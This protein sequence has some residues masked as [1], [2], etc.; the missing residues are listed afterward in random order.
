M[1][2]T[3]R[4]FTAVRLNDECEDEDSNKHKA[5]ASQLPNSES[6]TNC[7]PTAHSPFPHIMSRVALCLLLTCE[8]IWEI[9]CK[10]G[11]TENGGSNRGINMPN[12]WMG[13]G[14]SH[15]FGLGQFS[16]NSRKSSNIVKTIG[17]A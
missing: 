7:V 11:S 14:H 16:T 9:I 13:N 15:Q 8:V 1:K 6:E 10:N 12:G 2:R 4:T 3:E 17:K 5:I